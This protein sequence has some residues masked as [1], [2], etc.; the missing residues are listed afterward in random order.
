[1]ERRAADLTG[2][3][4]A[5][6]YPS[7]VEVLIVGAGPTGLALAVELRAYGV[8][9]RLI[10]R[11][12]DRVHE[13]RA[14]AIQP[15]TLEVLA[16]HGLAQ[17]LVDL[18]NPAVRLW[19]HAGPRVVPIELFDVGVADSAYPFLLFLSQAETER[20]LCEHLQRAGLPVERGV[21][22]IGLDLDG[23]RAGC[24]LRHADGREET[25]SANYVVGCDGA[26]STVRERA[27]I[28][29][30]GRAYPQ[31][32]LLAD[33]EVD[34]LEPIDGRGGGDRNGSVA[35]S[36]LTG[37][38]ILFFFPLGTPATWRMLAIRP[39]GNTGEVTLAE[40][41]QVVDASVTDDLRL[42]DPVWTTDFRLHV[43]G[44]ARYRSGPVFLAGD[45]A[46]IHSPAGGQGMNTGIQDSAN[47]G[48][49]LALVSRGEAPP[50]LLDTYDTERAPVGRAVLRLTDRLFTIAT[51]TSPIVRTARTRIVPVLAP[52]ALRF[53]P[54]RAAAFR[55]LSQ[56]NIRYRRSPLSVDGPATANCET[57]PG[58]R[59]PD[60]PYLTKPG[61]HLLLCGPPG[62][63]PPEHDTPAEGAPAAD[64]P[65][66]VTL[67]RVQATF[68]TQYLVRPDGY[69]G[70]RASGTDLSG[71]RAY[72]ARWLPG[73]R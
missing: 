59:M 51:T 41:Q 48:W 67:H 22:L 71:L 1:V 39:P 58:E 5:G 4:P 43:R 63:W 40:L 42:R 15:R 30:A 24:R 12:P 29:F 21:E 53:R 26:H 6:R 65:G 72:L 35:H 27:G 13:S 70:Y 50:A 20:V 8:P 69:V 62:A 7:A 46:H 57:R 18:G 54:G 64:W 45:A 10:D 44:A 19:L 9:F 56:L 17:P 25:A 3:T 32:F 23:D 66:L 31:T 61:F 14:L 47:L 55:T 68:P 34:G 37:G 33:L 52:V 49:K 60:A 38:G 16:R 11:Q 2:G 28:G 36:Y 73:P